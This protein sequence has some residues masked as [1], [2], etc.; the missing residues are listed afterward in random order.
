MA[1][2]SGRGIAR[3]PVLQLEGRH[4]RGSAAAR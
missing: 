2:V 3:Q 1:V 4:L